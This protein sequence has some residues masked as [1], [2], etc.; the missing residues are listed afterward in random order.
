MQKVGAV[1]YRSSEA[2]LIYCTVIDFA[3][4]GIYSHPIKKYE[5]VCYRRTF[6]LKCLSGKCT[7]NMRRK[8]IPDKFTQF[9]Q[10]V[11]NLHPR[12]LLYTDD[13]FIITERSFT[14]FIYNVLRITS[15]TSASLTSFFIF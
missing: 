10:K 14:T 5:S 12:S 2:R 6:L 13:A 11:L 3:D 8:I 15:T 4:G 7:Q 1:N 9:L